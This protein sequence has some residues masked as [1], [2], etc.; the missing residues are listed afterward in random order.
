MRRHQASA[1]GI[2]LVVATTILMA[3]FWL[4]E[5]IA[6]SALLVVIPVVPGL[7]ALARADGGAVE[8]WRTRLVNAGFAG[9]LVGLAVAVAGIVPAD[10]A[11]AAAAQ[12]ALMLAGL[13]FAVQTSVV[14]IVLSELLALGARLAGLDVVGE[15]G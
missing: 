10:S 15:D 8:W 5:W 2:G 9:T 3:E 13:G 7:V 4:R 11:E 6:Q 1:L 14:G 12:S